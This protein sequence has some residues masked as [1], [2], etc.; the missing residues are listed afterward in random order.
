[1]KDSKDVL[2]EYFSEDNLRL[3]FERYAFTKGDQKDY[4]GI[5]I[6]ESNLKDN[7]KDL[8]LRL[9]DNKYNPIKPLKFYIHKE[10]KRINSNI[11]FALC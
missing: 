5:K 9:I 4:S 11:Y 8:S 1:M 6:F 10:N 3:A 7:I 2:K